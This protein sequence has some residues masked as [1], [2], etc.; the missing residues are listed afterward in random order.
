MKNWNEVMKL[1]EKDCV[2]L[3]EYTYMYFNTALLRA[4]YRRPWLDDA[5]CAASDQGLQ[6]LSLYKSGFHSLKHI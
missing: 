6:Y 5:L 3:G 1:Y 4:K 2:Y